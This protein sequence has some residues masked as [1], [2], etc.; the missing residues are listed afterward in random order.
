M[1][2]FPRRVK[3]ELLGARVNE[4]VPAMSVFPVHG[5]DGLY[6]FTN[7]IQDILEDNNFH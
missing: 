4:L 2:V 3:T 7:A 1:L 5:S 6:L